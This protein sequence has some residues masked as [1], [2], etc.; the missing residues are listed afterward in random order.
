MVSSE[1][2]LPEDFDAAFYTS[3]RNKGGLIFVTIAMFQSFRTIEA[4]IA[5]HFEDSN[6]VYKLDSFQVCIDAISGSGIHPLFCDK[7]RD[8]SLPFLIMEYVHV[9]YHFE[10]KRYKDKYLS[11]LSAKNMS[12][13]KVQKCK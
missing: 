13:D 6:H 2:E 12:D 1:L 8:D 4:K 7:H 10:S 5:H 11:R 3:L 9:R